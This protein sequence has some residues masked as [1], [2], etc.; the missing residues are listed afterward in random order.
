MDR[1]FVFVRACINRRFMGGIGGYLFIS[2]GCP[3]CVYI[4][5]EV[6]IFTVSIAVVSIFLSTIHGIYI[7]CIGCMLKKI[8]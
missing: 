6:L 7:K 2:G 5:A 4:E 1:F 8:Q 3:S